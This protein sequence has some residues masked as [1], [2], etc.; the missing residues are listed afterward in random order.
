MGRYRGAGGAVFEMEEPLTE[1]M[2]N[3]LARG[4]LVLVDEGGERVDNGPPVQPKPT[5]SKAEWVGYAVAVSKTTDKPI[6]IDDADAMTKSD[7]IEKY[8]T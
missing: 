5:A 1:N 2:R 6:T 7:L 8:G 3:Q 4:E